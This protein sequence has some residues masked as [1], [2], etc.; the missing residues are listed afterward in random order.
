[1]QLLKAHANCSNLMR[2]Y[3]WISI[4]SRHQKQNPME[5]TLPDGAIFEENLGE[6]GCFYEKKRR[7]VSD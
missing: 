1:M 7:H 4:E 3:L 6:I 5:K 2:F